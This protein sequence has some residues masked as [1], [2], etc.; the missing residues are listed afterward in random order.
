MRKKS[1]LHGTQIT[2]K[3]PLNAFEQNKHFLSL[4]LTKF[5]NDVDN[6]SELIA[7]MANDYSDLRFKLCETFRLFGNGNSYY[8][9]AEGDVQS[10]CQGVT[11]GY[12]K[13]RGRVPKSLMLN[14]IQKMIE[15]NDVEAFL[16]QCQ[17]IYRAAQENEHIDYYE[18]VSYQQSYSVDPWDAIDQEDIHEDDDDF[19]SVAIFEQ[20]EAART[21]KAGNMHAR[22]RPLNNIQTHQ[23][24]ATGEEE[25]SVIPAASISYNKVAPSNNIFKIPSPKFCERISLASAETQSYRQTPFLYNSS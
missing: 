6:L 16:T 25:V 1:A 17:S 15:N 8:A 12:V 10:L 7:D 11:F 14:K 5:A 9:G 19:D 20:L 3:S 24:E 2:Q 22:I 21:V 13:N 18:Y 4:A 23:E